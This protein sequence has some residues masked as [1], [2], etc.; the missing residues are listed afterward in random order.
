MTSARGGRAFTG[1]TTG[2]RKKPRAELAAIRAHNDAVAVHNQLSV[3]FGPSIPADVLREVGNRVLSADGGRLLGPLME[4]S[5][6]R[7][8][9]SRLRP[10]CFAPA[11]S[12]RPETPCSTKNGAY[13]EHRQRRSRHDNRR[14]SRT[15]RPVSDLRRH[16]S[17]S[18]KPGSPDRRV[19]RVFQCL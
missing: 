15:P 7:S 14:V 19:Q 12:R 1:A 4:S 9:P 8:L 13:C 16:R 10:K 18:C 17:A 2:L 11:R 5:G 6:W 3:R